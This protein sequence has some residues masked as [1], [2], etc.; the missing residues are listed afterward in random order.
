MIAAFRAI[1]LAAL[2]LT[3]AGKAQ[4][5]TTYTILDFAALD[6]ATGADSDQWPDNY[7]LNQTTEFRDLGDG[8][9]VRIGA[10]A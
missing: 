9:F 8:H 1:F 7:S 6:G 10:S 2:V 3:G 5:E 4:S